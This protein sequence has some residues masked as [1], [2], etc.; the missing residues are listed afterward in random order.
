M[1]RRVDIS[2][3]AVLAL[4]QNTVAVSNW[5]DCIGS[6]YPCEGFL[7]ETCQNTIGERIICVS[8]RARV[9]ARASLRLASI[10]NPTTRV[11]AANGS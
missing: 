5:S 1:K 4:V 8:L 9:S 11:Q 2:I 7:Q 10:P 6:V 3:L